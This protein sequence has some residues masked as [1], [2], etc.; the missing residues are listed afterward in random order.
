MELNRRPKG[1]APFPNPNGIPSLSPGWRNAPTL[2]Y[3][4]KMFSTLNGLY[5]FRPRRSNSFRVVFIFSLSPSVARL[6]RP[7]LG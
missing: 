2:G 1:F 3:V 7:T 5:P 4:P 6:R